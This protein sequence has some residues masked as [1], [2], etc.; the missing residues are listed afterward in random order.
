ML[1]LV[2]NI[3]NK[4]KLIDDWILLETSD[5]PIKVKTKIVKDNYRMVIDAPKS[6]KIKRNLD[7]ENT[8]PV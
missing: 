7:D 4:K 6:V 8:K 1:M 5:G 3:G 2:I